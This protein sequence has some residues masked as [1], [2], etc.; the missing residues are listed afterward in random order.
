MGRNGRSVK[1]SAKPTLVRVEVCCAR[2]VLNGLLPPRRPR[3]STRKVKSPLSRWN[4]ADPH[5]PARS[6]PVTAMGITVRPPARPS[7]RHSDNSA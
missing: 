1:P 4:K 2:A 6:T 7:P 3:V 5:R